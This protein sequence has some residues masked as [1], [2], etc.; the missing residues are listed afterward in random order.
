MKKTSKILLISVLTIVF[1]ASVIVGATFA[2]FTGKD[3]VDI[4][5]TS[6]KV[7]IKASFSAPIEYSQD[8]NED[9]MSHWLSGSAAKDGDK[10]VLNNIA[11]YDGVRFNIYITNSG[12]AVKWQIQVE[13]IAEDENGQLLFEYL[14]IDITE[15]SED[16]SDGDKNDV[17]L[18]NT[19]STSRISDWRT[20][21]A[22]TGTATTQTET[23]DANIQLRGDAPVA[24]QGSSCTIKLTV[25]A[26]QA[27]AETESPNANALVAIS[28]ADELQTFCQQV[29]SGEDFTGRTVKLVNNIDLNSVANWQPIGTKDKVFNGTFDG[30]NCTIFNV[31]SNQTTDSV[32]FF[33]YIGA[34]GIVQNVTFDGAAI[35]GTTNCGVVV[36]S[37]AS[38]AKVDNVKVVRSSVAGQ[39]NLGGIVGRGS[40]TITECEVDDISVIASIQN[41][42]GGD[43]VGGIIGYCNGGTLTSCK[44]VNSYLTATDNLGALVGCYDGTDA[45]SKVT[46]VTVEN[47]TLINDQTDADGVDSFNVHDIIGTVSGGNA[48]EVNN[49]LKQ[50]NS[51]S[52]VTIN[53]VEKDYEYD[54]Q[55]DFHVYSAKGL[56]KFG[57]IVDEYVSGS[58]VGD[59][60]QNKTVF[61][62]NDVDL[63]GIEWAPVGLLHNESFYGTFDGKGN[64]IYNLTINKPSSSY[65]GFISRLAG[66]T[67]GVKNVT[68]KNATI[69]GG[70]YTGVVVGRAGAS[71]NPN[72]TDVTIE[73]RIQV[74][75]AYYVGGF[76]GHMGAIVNKVTINA[77]DKSFVNGCFDVGGIAGITRANNGNYSHLTTNIAVNANVEVSGKIYGNV[78]GLV[79]REG[80]GNT[81]SDCTVICNLYSAGSDSYNINACFGDVTA[82]GTTVDRFTFE[83]AI[84][85]D[86]FIGFCDPDV[87]DVKFTNSTA[88]VTRG[89][90]TITYTA[91][92]SGDITNSMN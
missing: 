81:Y 56:V 91:N 90:Q 1:C 38:G 6:G 52:N 59:R 29:N 7:E 71:G 50:A 79:G 5:V 40:L 83:G 32:G 33:G 84:E 60:F 53:D 88:V 78:G 10:L 61:L 14:N 75:G 77:D 17:L 51:I 74:I 67:G 3:D 9:E 76:I 20:L 39:S 31:T 64:I 66:N 55:G 4:S 62:E 68:F 19:S 34:S 49:Q 48:D 18:Y 58:N 35:M 30:N 23:L 11:P 43:N 45:V 26:V 82:N 89:G 57:E 47:V 16:S 46:T 42:V 25:F 15:H 37:A 69:V 86:S 22:P 21:S 8:E 72:F 27:N 92:E 13:L 73:G 44:A 28:S 85:G 63:T 41:D 12:I 65:V 70:S 2:M 80:G 87:T 24:T 36:G 54:L